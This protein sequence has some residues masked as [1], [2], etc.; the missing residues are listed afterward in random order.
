MLIKCSEC[1][2]EISDKAA[3]CPTCGAPVSGNIQTIQETSKKLKAQQFI[4][5]TLLI[6]GII[7][8][9]NGDPKSSGDDPTFGGLAVVIGLFWYIA[10]KIKIWWHHK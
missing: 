9:F 6:I 8:I 10:V 4:A 7:I 2:K 5:V 3:A 1:G